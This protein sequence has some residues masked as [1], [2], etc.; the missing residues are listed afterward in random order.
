[1][2]EFS[3][4]AT[5]EKNKLST[6]APFLICI[7]VDCDEIGEPIY[8]VRNID[9]VQWN[10]RIWTAYPIDIENYEED[11]K[12]LPALN[13]KISAGGG[14]LVTY[15]QQYRGLT[16]AKVNLY[17]INAKLLD[18]NTPEMELNFQIT[19]TQY[20]ESWVTFTLGPAPELANRYPAWKYLTDF[21]PYVCGDIRCGYQGNEVC[22][23]NLASCLMPARFG[24]EP[25][26]QAGR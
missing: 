23:N 2:L 14:L 9:D 26:I 21:C 15:L 17:I 4:I 13:L 8:L 16:D 22:Q 24:G 10:G 25:G 18:V 5:L 19:S 11:G 12:T 7:E 3:R 6:D 1:M 20:D